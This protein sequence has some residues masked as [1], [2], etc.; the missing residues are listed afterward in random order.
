M[1]I[2]NP[3]PNIVSTLQS[4][5][6]RGFKLG[7]LSNC[8]ERE[9]REWSNSPLEQYFNAVCFS[10]DIGHTKPYPMTYAT[11]LEKLETT[12]EKS[13][14]MGDGGSSE[15]EGAKKAGFGLVVFM[16]GFVSTNCLRKPSESID[17]NDAS[18]N[19]SVVSVGT[20]R[21]S[22]TRK[23]V[24]NHRSATDQYYCSKRRVDAEVFESWPKQSGV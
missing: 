23:M 21:G 7:L 1:A 17:N 18:G 3:Q 4:L 11:I 22:L 2:L 8:D 24:F 14:Y 9:I 12:A 13:V 15:L 5:S 20:M 16:E 10:C 19:N 6:K